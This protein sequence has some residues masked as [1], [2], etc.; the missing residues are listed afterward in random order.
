MNIVKNWLS[1]GKISTERRPEWGINTANRWLGRGWYWFESEGE[2][3]WIWSSGVAHLNPSGCD[4][5]DLKFF[6]HYADFTGSRQRVSVIV[7]DQ[8]QFSEFFASGTHRISI[9]CEN[10]QSVRL[11]VDVIC[12]A[13][14]PGHTDRRVLGIG[15]CSLRPTL[16]NK[17]TKIQFD[18]E[19]NLHPDIAPITMQ[20]EVSTACH[21]SCVMCSRA[22]KTGGPSQHMKTEI[23]DN[24]FNAARH[25][26]AVNFLGLGEPWTHQHFLDFLRDL[27]HADVAISII[28][29]G[30]LINEERAKFLGEL[31]NLRDLTF[32]IDSPDPETYLKIRGQPLSRALMGLDRSIKAIS[33]P[34]VVRIH[35]VVM[36]DSLTSLARFPELLQNHSV[37]RF[38]M[39]GVNQMNPS[40]REMIPEYTQQEREI[41]IHIRDESEE[42]G[43]S[44]SLLPTLPEDLIQI[45]TSDFIQEQDSEQKSDILPPTDLP[46]T[47]NT[48][49]CM[50]PW[51][52]A[53]VTRDGDVYP[54]ECYHLQK[55]VGSL[56][57]QSFQ[58][59][60]RGDG[61]TAMRRGLLND[62][63]L[64]CRS[65][66]RRGWGHHPLNL[67]AAEIL[68]SKI[69][70]GDDC[71]I[72]LRNTGRV[73]WSDKYLIHLGTARPRD[74]MSSVFAHETWIS[75]NR[76]ASHMEQVV[77]AGEVGTFRFIL[78]S[79]AEPA[80]LEYFQFLVEHHCW[81]PNTEI[82]LPMIS[83]PADQVGSSG[84]NS[85]ASSMPTGIAAAV[86][87][88]RTSS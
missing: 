46:E 23:W 53:I 48:K 29:T 40:T 63:N 88:S 20:I 52:K 34:Q 64:G 38:V 16:H 58:E 41:L 83:L 66:E 6:T 22:A 74:R 25:A 17:P 56:A 37:K 30:D 59:I 26:E 85:V 49:I 7:D 44:V 4:R 61:Y 71:E 70:P 28:T 69:V 18:Q 27:D 3:Q 75:P 51:E 32:S 35:A 36:R 5:F 42:S 65:C 62:Q 9:K 54:C 86:P 21:L 1:L 72:I 12:P 2:G 82:P 24:F 50:D 14:Y 13:H 47:R 79:P 73:D 31:K 39:R 78:T 45:A 76:I 87:G 19:I 77:S 67:F 10:A 11:E 80:P 43:I 84:T 55:S 60:W 68:S 33:D 15:L 57:T 8:V 81:L